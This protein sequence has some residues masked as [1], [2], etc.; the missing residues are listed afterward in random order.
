MEGGARAPSV[1]G[2]PESGHPREPAPA[3][4]RRRRALATN[5]R[6]SL[7]VFHATRSRALVQVVP[8]ILLAPLAASLAACGGGGGGGNA[9]AP[10]DAIALAF[11]PPHG[12][13]D[14]IGFELLGTTARPRRIARIEANGIPGATRDGFN[15]WNVAVALSAP[16]TDFSIDALD[17]AS[18]VLSQEATSIEFAPVPEGAQDL[19][20]DPARNQ[21]LACE[22]TNRSGLIG[23]DLAT[24][25]PIFVSGPQRGAGPDFP[26]LIDA[27]TVDAAHDRAFVLGQL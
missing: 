3:P 12:L 4:I 14:Q 26:D 24:G 8:A 17:G 10:A 20:F 2:P 18:Q 21:I 23:L 27:V 22:I 19:D 15:H 25:R 6:R 9:A 11:P 7:A 13:T 5:S 16:T 1:R